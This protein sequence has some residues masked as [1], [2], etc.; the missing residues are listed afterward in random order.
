MSAS[1]RGTAAATVKFSAR[2]MLIVSPSR[3]V[4]PRTLPSRLLMVPRTRTATPGGGAGVAAGAAGA[5]GGVWANV[6]GVSMRTPAAMAARALTGLARFVNI[7]P[8]GLV[9]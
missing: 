2:T 7:G 1:V 6:I 4:K 3:V 9:H 5:A 8:P